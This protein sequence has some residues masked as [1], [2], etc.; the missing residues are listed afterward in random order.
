[1]KSTFLFFIACIVITTWGC[2]K[3]DTTLIEGSRLDSLTIRK[4]S[5]NSVEVYQEVYLR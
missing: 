1:M 4:L 5:D 3:N 2:K